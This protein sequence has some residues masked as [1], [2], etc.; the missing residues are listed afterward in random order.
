[1]L[2]CGNHEI[3]IYDPEGE[4]GK[5][6]FV[7]LENGMFVPTKEWDLVKRVMEGK[8]SVNLQIKLWA[9]DLGYLLMPDELSNYCKEY[10]KW[11][12]KATMEQA[13][14]RIIKEVGFIPSFVRFGDVT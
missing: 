6:S 11:V 9:N 8:K 5:Y 10:P 14:K 13:Q 12:F 4:D 1:M 7:C 3:P 2:Q